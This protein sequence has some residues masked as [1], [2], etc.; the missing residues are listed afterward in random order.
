MLSGGQRQRVA[1]ARAISVRPEF[2]VADE[3]VSALDL[4]VQAQV[5]NLLADIRERFGLTYL[6]ISH[7]LN[8]I[9]YLSDRVAVMHLGKLVE[10]A[11]ARGLFEQPLHPY[12][13]ALME[14]APR[15][16]AGRRQTLS[17]AARGEIQAGATRPAGCAYHP[18]C[19]LARP[20]CRDVEPR[21]TEV[22]PA[23]W[24]ACHVVE[25]EE[26]EARSAN[27]VGTSEL[28]ATGTAARPRAAEQSG[29]ER[30]AP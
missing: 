25:E 13:R 10:A 2:I 11:P 19:P 26:K 24:V 3:P 12:T 30:P 18:R 21:W 23:H 6:F 22:R 28:V 14:A 15:M 8:V 29:G 20:V 9:R 1:V 7:D 17:V 4:S 27:T 16:D 5:L